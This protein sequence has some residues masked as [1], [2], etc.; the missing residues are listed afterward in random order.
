MGFWNWLFGKQ[1]KNI[2]IPFATSEAKPEFVP[3]TP[4]MTVTEIEELRRKKEA[5]NRL[6]RESHRRNVEANDALIYAS[7]DAS[8]AHYDGGSSDCGGADGGGCD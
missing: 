8:P 2:G 4:R 3:F 6:N 1:E 7:I 5:Q